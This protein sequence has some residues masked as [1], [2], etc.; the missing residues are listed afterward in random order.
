MIQFKTNFALLLPALLLAAC[1]GSSFN[2]DADATDAAVI[3]TRAPDY[4]AGA[5]SLVGVDTPYAAQT[6]VSTSTTSDTFVRSGGDHFFVIKRFGSDQVLRYEARTPSTPTWTYSTQDA[7]DG[8]N[9]S[10]PSDLII[11]SP[12]KAYLLRYGSGKLWIVNP[13][14][15]SE[16]NFKTGE[17]DL[18]SYDGDGIPEM[19]AGLIKDGKLYV[20]LQR[21]TN[22]DAT[23]VGSVV[24]IDVASNAVQRSIDLP[25]YNPGSLA[26]LPASNKILV[27]AAGSYGSYPDYVTQYNGG[28]VSLDTSS[29]TASL[30]L[31]D[32]DGSTH[33]YGQFLDLAVVASDRAY[34]IGST[35]FGAD[36]TLYRINPSVTPIAPVIVSGFSTKAL[37]S[38]AVDPAGKLWVGRTDDDAPGVSILGYSG[39]SETVAAALVDTV[40][41]PINIDFV[42]V[43]AE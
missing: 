26:A 12:T 43:P 5:V 40:L 13:S 35:G 39:G 31:D 42:S 34:F 7:S 3:A 33:A 1:G 4:S 41:T 19:T 22:F 21:L 18:S 6:N 11:A 2:D 32:G 8:S 20:L 23:Q 24:V 29:N 17:I 15:T 27:I 25:V 38:L 9:D 36:Q 16:A 37:G 30:V 28:L 14:A 10:N